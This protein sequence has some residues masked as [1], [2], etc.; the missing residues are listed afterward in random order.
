MGPASV[1][2]GI[3]SVVCAMA[4]AF[5]VIVPKAGVALSILAIAFSLASIVCGGVG[6]SQASARGVDDAMSTTGVIIGVLGF[7]TSFLL[8]MTCG[9]CNACLTFVDSQID[10]GLSSL[11]WDG[12]SHAPTWDTDAGKPPAGGHAFGPLDAAAPDV[13]TSPALEDGG[14]RPPPP[15]F[16]PPP[17]NR[18][19]PRANP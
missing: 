4:S 13:S 10:G 8:A 6:M 2:L 3:L 11:P 19:A 18:I 1:L 12:G 17:M 5:L 16:P 7:L 9:A 15:A 14:L